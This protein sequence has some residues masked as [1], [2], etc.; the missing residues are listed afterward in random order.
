MGKT[1]T[2]LPP[3]PPPGRE[4]HE[5]FGETKRSK[6]ARE[7]WQKENERREKHNAEIRKKRMTLIEQKETGLK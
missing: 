1:E 7:E 4:F 5:F 3:L 2:P 6:K